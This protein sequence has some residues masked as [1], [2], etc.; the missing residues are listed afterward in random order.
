LRWLVIGYYQKAIKCIIR[1]GASKNYNMINILPVHPSKS[2]LVK[3][4]LQR[5]VPKT[6]QPITAQDC[7]C[8]AMPD[9]NVENGRIDNT[10][11]N[12]P[13]ET[14]CTNMMV[15]GIVWK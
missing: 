3:S 2:G 9:I 14:G 13:R 7:C 12:D 1:Q 11:R 6:P 8:W 15:G 5:L 10:C 4:C